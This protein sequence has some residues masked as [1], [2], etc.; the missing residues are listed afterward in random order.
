MSDVTSALIFPIVVGIVVLVIEYWVIHPLQAYIQK[1]KAANPLPRSPGAPPQRKPKVQLS[2]WLLSVLIATGLIAFVF[3]FNAFVGLPIP[4]FDR[5]GFRFTRLQDLDANIIAALLIYAFIM[6]IFVATRITHP[7]AKY[8]YLFVP[9]FMLICI[10]FLYTSYFYY[11]L[12]LAVSIWLIGALISLKKI[13]NIPFTFRGIQCSYLL[14]LCLPLHALYLI[15]YC[16]VG[17]GWGW[18][19]AITTTVFLTTGVALADEVQPK[20]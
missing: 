4:T 14:A 8:L 9:S 7:L 2:W 10:L 20:V 15:Y 1:R 19:W 17:T 12:P 11:L 3:V 5:S 16:D 18:M 6:Y 13:G